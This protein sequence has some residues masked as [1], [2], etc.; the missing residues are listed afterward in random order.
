MSRKRLIREDYA[1]M[2][3]ATQE[4]AGISVGIRK[5][6]NNALSAYYRA[7]SVCIPAPAG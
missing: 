4:L 2:A 3:V 5:E 1:A 7:L 6:M